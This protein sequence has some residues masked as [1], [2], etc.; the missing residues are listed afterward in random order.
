MRMNNINR[1]EFE[2]L[3]RKDKPSMSVK[4]FGLD[5][6]ICGTYYY[7]ICVTQLFIYYLHITLFVPAKSS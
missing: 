4:P 6:Y 7:G 2:T 1:V 5:A 3:S